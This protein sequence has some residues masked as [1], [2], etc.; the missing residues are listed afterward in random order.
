MRSSNCTLGS[1]SAT[2]DREAIPTVAGDRKKANAWGRWA[3]EE[4]RLGS[5]AGPVC[6]AR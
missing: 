2:F 6:P 3:E 4:K 5:F 1:V